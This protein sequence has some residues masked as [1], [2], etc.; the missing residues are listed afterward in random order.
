M[1]KVMLLYPPGNIYQRGEDRS[2][3]NIEDSAATTIRACNDL[4]YAASM[5]QRDHFDVFLKDYQTERLSIDDLL[6][7]FQNYSPDIIFVSITNATIFS[8][9]EIIRELKRNKQELVVILKGALFFDAEKAMMD[10]LNL[11]DIDYL[12]GGESDFIISDLVT[13]H[14]S[15]RKKIISIRGIL[16]KE[17]NE[18]HKTDFS[19]WDANLDR[20]SF[21]DRSLMNNRLYVRPDTGEPQATIATSRGCPSSCTYCLTPI[22]SGRKVRYR[23]PENIFN[24][25]SECYFKYNIKNFFFKSDTFTINKDWVLELCDYISNSDL[26]GKIEW[27]ANSRVKP[28][29]KETLAAMKNAGCWLVAFGFES[30][31][32]ESLKRIKKG[33]EVEDNLR[34]AE[35]AKQVGLKIFGFYLIGL[36]WEGQAH[37]DDTKKMIY[38]IDADF[39]EV[40]IATPYYGTELYEMAKKEELIDETVLGKDYFNSPTIGTKYL[41]INQLEEFKKKILLRY[42]LRPNYIYK[43]L[44]DGINNPKIFRNYFQFGMNLLKQNALH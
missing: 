5:L 1:K 27:V 11:T 23:T 19:S 35:Y 21:P 42:H 2:Q 18:W 33:S 34:A 30:G 17:N 3:G 8:D 37:L 32:P 44:L 20:L 39:I 13:Y 43:K 9:L 40:H 24:E 29:K 28:L 7:D 6:A 10:Q 4:G 16:Y 31:S 22:I 15:D 26:S 36:P 41:S 12:I 25:L 38:K 14:F